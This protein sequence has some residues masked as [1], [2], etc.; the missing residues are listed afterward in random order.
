M[1][2]TYYLRSCKKCTKHFY[3]TSKYSE[4]CGAHLRLNQRK[5][6]NGFIGYWSKD[7]RDKLKNGG[8]LDNK[9]T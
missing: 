5:L 4:N 9:I 1:A 8:V 2:K 6:W 3:T 7:L